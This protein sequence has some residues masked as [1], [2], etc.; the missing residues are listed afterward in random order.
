VF[1]LNSLG[2]A[3]MASNRPAAESVVDRIE[4]EAPAPLAPQPV[5]VEPESDLPPQDVPR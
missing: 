1:F 3:Y 2:L 5:P 4:I